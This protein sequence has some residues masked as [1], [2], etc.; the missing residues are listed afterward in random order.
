MTARQQKSALGATSQLGVGEARA[1][2]AAER[3]PDAPEDDDD[4]EAQ[5][6]DRDPLEHPRAEHVPSSR[7]RVPSSV[8]SRAFASVRR[9]FFE[10]SRW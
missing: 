1:L 7:A 5:A 6:R 4:G 10:R 8:S 3:R 9:G 2:A